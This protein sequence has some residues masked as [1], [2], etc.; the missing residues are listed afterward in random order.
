MSTAA[1]KL[2]KNQALGLSVRVT[3]QRL[4]NAGI[5][6]VKPSSSKQSVRDLRIPEKLTKRL[7]SA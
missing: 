1:K 5:Q 2:L 3:D 7:A 6:V 4:L